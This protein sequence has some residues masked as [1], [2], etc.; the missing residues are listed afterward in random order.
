MM[1]IILLL[2]LLTVNVTALAYT[3]SKQLIKADNTHSAQKD[4]ELSTSKLNS[5]VVENFSQQWGMAAIKIPA[6]NSQEQL[7]MWSA[8]ISSVQPN[9]NGST[10]EQPL[11]LNKINQPLN[12]INAAYTKGRFHAETGLLTNSSD[13]LDSG[14]F[15]LQGSY[16]IFT[17][18]KF[19]LAVTAKFEAVNNPF[20][21]TYLA[22]IEPIIDA[23]TIF[24]HQTKN[25]T[26][27][28]ISTYSINKKWK[29]LG[30]ITTTAYDQALQ[31]N[32][33]VD[34][35]NSHMALI[36]TSYSF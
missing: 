5:N 16:A 12:S 25:A 18:A 2:A 6:H 17:K 19:N 22:E 14:K 30:S 32:P 9:S 23:K 33:L 10:K 11:N 28:V 26:I 36:G 34:I 24:E 27:G 7:K 1:R 4:D 31:K 35:N 29:I 15:Y 21:N 13:V 3:D 20:F 8:N